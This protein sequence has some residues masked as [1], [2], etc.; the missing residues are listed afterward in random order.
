M[1]AFDRYIVDVLG[2]ADSMQQ[3]GRAFKRF[4]CPESPEEVREALP[5]EIGSGAHSGIILRGDTF[6]ELGNP[7]AGSCAYLLWTD[8]PSLI[9]DGRITV[10]GPDV[11]ESEGASLPFGQVLM[12]AGE[13]LLP[14]DHEKLQQVPIVGDRIEGYMVRSASENVWSRVGK[15]VAARGFDFEMLGK[16]LLSLAKSST[17]GV[18]AM[19]VLF[20]TSSKD[21]VNELSS[22]AASSKTVGSEILKETWKARGYDVD[23]DF[24]CAS[25][26][27]A[28][29]CDDIRDILATMKKNIREKSAAKAAK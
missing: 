25:C 15:D 28:D 16:S 7:T 20:V 27:D 24:D 19:E 11:P 23:C 12:L 22:I 9:R 3:R 2:F 8:E 5:I 4:D 14:K 18:T 21:D 13:E 6:L 17:G 26:H 10:F 1:A 29:V